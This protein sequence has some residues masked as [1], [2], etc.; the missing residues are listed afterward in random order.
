MSDNFLSFAE[1]VGKDVGVILEGFRPSKERTLDADEDL[2]TLLETGVYN[3][4]YNM[5]DWQA[6]N[7]PGNLKGYVV[8]DTMET[9]NYITQYF[10]SRSNM[11]VPYIAYRFMVTAGWSPWVQIQPD[12][13]SYSPQDTGWRDITSLLTAPVTS[14]KVLVRRTDNLVHVVLDALLLNATGTTTIYRFDSP[15]RPDYKKAGS[16]YIDG[17][18]V[19]TDGSFQ[20]SSA[21]YF[22]IYLVDPNT[23]MTANFSFTCSSSWPTTPPGTPA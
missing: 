20:I 6:Q 21:G 9:V 8:V 2:N 5:A 11:N 22:P 10:Y 16:W 14:G 15:F 13:P 17:S 1:Q 12:P 19:P 4:T 18:S 7:Y 3:A 23:A